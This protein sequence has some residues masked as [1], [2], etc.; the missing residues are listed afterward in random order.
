MDKKEIN[1]I[2]AL[3]GETPLKVKEKR[4]VYRVTTTQGERCLKEV[5]GK[6]D[7]IIFMIDAMDYVKQQGF[8][9]FADCL[10]ALDGN[11]VVKHNSSSYLVQEWLEGKEPDYRNGYAIARAAETI[12]MFHRAGRGFFPKPSCKA[13]NKLG[14]WPKKL[15]KKADQLEHYLCMAESSS[16][17][18]RFEK[19]LIKYGNWLRY[20]A[21]ESLIKLKNSKYQELVAA[22]REGG[23]LVHGDTAVRNFVMINGVVYLIDFDSIAIDI[24]VTDL[25]RLLRRTLRRQQW[26]IHLV[27]KILD[28]YRRCFSLNRREKEVLLAFLEF[29]EKPW[30]IAKEY[31]E[32]R[33]EKGWSEEDL[34]EKLSDFLNQH[35]EIDEFLE[36]FRRSIE[37]C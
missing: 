13:K 26:D 9:R 15:A 34:V 12:A 31:Y 32:K 23:S 33:L 29:P 28:S 25:W 27:E 35:Q 14:R 18:S 4:G 7:R 24:P 1:E 2:M 8:K 22:A 11:M 3:W 19:I 10:P 16:H 5:T 17:P 6:V 37:Q 20:H 30:R 36:D 21:R